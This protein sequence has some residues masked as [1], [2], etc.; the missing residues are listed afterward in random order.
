MKPK[1]RK[2]IFI[3]P[4]LLVHGVLLHSCKKFVEIAEPVDQLN[5]D[6]VF[7]DSSTATSAIT[8]IYSEM[9][10]NRNLFSNSAVTLYAGMS[11]DELNYYTPGLKDEFI[12]NQ[13]SLANHE[14]I[15]NSFWK[16]AYKYIYAANLAIEKISQSSALSGT[17]KNQLTG[18]AKLVRAFCY[19]HLVNLFGDV[20]LITASKYTENVSSPRAAVSAIYNQIIK[21]LQDA[22][23]LLPATYTTSERTRP[24]KWTAAALLSRCY[25]YTGNWHNAEAE[26]TAII[27]SEQYSLEPDLNKV[28]LSS[29]TEA[30]WQLMP[31]RPGF[32]T[33]EGLEILPASSFATPT[34]LVTPGL[35]TVFETGDKRKAAWINSRVFNND[36]LYYPF[37][38]KIP[39]NGP[40]N[41]YYLVFRLAEQFLIRAEAETNLHQISAAQADINIIRSRAG[42]SNTMAGDE[43]SLITAIEQERR[44]ELFCEWGHRW[45]DLKRTGRSNA[46][47]AG[48]KGEGWQDTDTLWPI[49]Q[50]EINLNP[51]LTQ[52]P[53]Y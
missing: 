7:R 10:T 34:Y 15:D 17:L 49:P 35:L 43:Q 20:P 29:S 48:L 50:P 53:G 9:L 28:F 1:Y 5:S 3:I 23:D 18:E 33:T 46:L 13:I 51:S 6:A 40:L 38:Y 36:T 14:S 26:A 2:T 25:L 19:F 22:K 42:L 27:D 30:I 41:E 4:L 39:F 52:N 24:N 16:P 45:Y 47:L 31:V 8:G 21:D 37:K 44:V 12:Q 11:A 32:N